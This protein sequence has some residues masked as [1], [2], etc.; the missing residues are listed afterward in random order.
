MRPKGN[1]EELERRRRMAIDFLQK[2]RTTK[3]VAEFLGCDPRS[4]RRWRAAYDKNKD[5]GLAPIPPPGRPSRLTARQK[6]ALVGRLLKGA[7]ANGFST[8]LWTCRRIAQ[9]IE[10]R[11]EIRYHV[12][13]MPR[14]LAA[15]GFSYQKPQKR[16]VER[17]EQ[18]IARWVARD[19][20]ADKKNAARKRA[21]LIFLDESGFSLIPTVKRTWGLRG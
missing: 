9:L 15:L 6:K 20:A 14:F 12:C 4:V 17:D 19:L 10:R 3:Q 13:S 11:Y 5:H 2:G 16:A 21:H 1:A 8:D 18:A 7:K